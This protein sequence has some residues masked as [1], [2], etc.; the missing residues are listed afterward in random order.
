MSGNVAE[1]TGPSEAEDVLH[2][3]F[4]EAF[5]HSGRFEPERGSVLSWLVVRMRS[6]SLDRRK[7]AGPRR[8]V[9]ETAMHDCPSS[10]SDQAELEL[11][12]RAIDHRRLSGAIGDLEQPHAE[13]LALG[14]LEDLSCSEIGARL[15]IPVGTVKSRVRRALGILREKL[16]GGTREGS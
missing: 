8:R 15:G 3:V 16:H 13:V 1:W 7:S 4:L 6:R 9:R 14:Y 5:R 11:G 10:P 2:D 12:A